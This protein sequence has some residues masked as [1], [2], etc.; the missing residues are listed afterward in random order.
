MY[1]L[2]EESINEDRWTKWDWL[3]LSILLSIAI[4]LGF[5]IYKTE[6]EVQRQSI[7]YLKLTQDQFEQLLMINQFRGRSK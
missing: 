7:I 2:H 5:Y 3:I 1:D 4:G 6:G